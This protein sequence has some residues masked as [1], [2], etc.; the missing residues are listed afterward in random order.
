MF[1]LPIFHISFLLAFFRNLL[2]EVY[3]AYMPKNEPVNR[4]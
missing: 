3:S 4:V 2:L 1:P